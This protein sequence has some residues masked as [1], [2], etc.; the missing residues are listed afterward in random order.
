MGT[1]GFVALVT[2]LMAQQGQKPNVFLEPNVKLDCWA[3]P[4]QTCHFSPTDKSAPAEHQVE[5]RTI[6]KDQGR[7]NDLGGCLP[8]DKP[9]NGECVRVTHEI[10]IDGVRWGTLKYSE[11]PK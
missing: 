3:G 1:A 8:W 2:L 4:G 5:I 7:A 9:K 11:E 10:W 6:D